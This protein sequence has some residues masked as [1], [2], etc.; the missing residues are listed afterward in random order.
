MDQNLYNVDKKVTDKGWKAM[1]EILDRE[2]PTERP[3]RRIWILW[4]LALLLPAA[5]LLLWLNPA[6][7]TPASPVSSAERPI[8]EQLH[9]QEHQPADRK[10]IA[11]ASAARNEQV[12]PSEKMEQFTSATPLSL[13]AST[14]TSAAKRKATAIPAAPPATPAPV[15]AAT[16]TNLTE[17]DADVHTSTPPAIN[18]EINSAAATPSPVLIPAPTAPTEPDADIQAS[19]PPATSPEIKTAAAASAPVLA[20]APTT[21][22]EQ[23]T[24]PNA[25]NPPATNAEVAPVAAMPSPVLASVPTPTTVEQGA[26]PATP[27]IPVRENKKSLSWG[28]TVGVLSETTPG[29]AGATAGLVAEWQPGKRW[30]L[31]SGLAYQFHLLR[32]E[33]RPITSV[34]TAAYAEATGDQ[35]IFDNAFTVSSSDFT[36]P[37]YVPVS[38]LHRLEIPLQVF[39]QPTR[40]VR[41]YAGASI[42]ANFY[43]QTASR[44]LK[45]GKIYDVQE[46]TPARNLNQEV[47][48]QIR[49]G[50]IG[51]NVGISYQPTKRIEL[52]LFFQNPV[53]SKHAEPQFQDVAAP[54]TSNALDVLRTLTAERQG[55]V[56]G[57]SVFQLSATAFF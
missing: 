19:T 34:T 39:W 26:A 14:T 49:G 56:N 27:I 52:G 28:A 29:Y 36:V 13:A 24:E 32:D 3:R 38:R 33:D 5:G 57:R 2:M 31:R 47:S 51:W 43:A 6:E 8:A 40:N 25:S 45:N 17:R 50:Q 18:S 48:R 41:L 15:S 37:V 46:G 1:Q 9:E 54:N 20:D 35:T 53:T 44:S 55:T 42:G 4:F 22:A 21:P 7:K 12:A 11:G 10:I 16:P 30:G 23:N